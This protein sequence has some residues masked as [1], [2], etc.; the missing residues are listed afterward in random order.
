M[1]QIIYVDILIAVNLFINYFL[2]LVTAKFL[3][4]K[5][6]TWRVIIG[7]ILGGIYSLYILMPST[8]L[9]VSLLI[10]FFM[11]LTIVAVTFKF[12][13]IK[14]LLKTLICFY[15]INFAFSG[16][17][18]ALW[19][20]FKPKSMA[21]N[22]GI[23]YFGISPTALVISTVITYIILETINRII[24][25][26]HLSASFCNVK[27]FYRN[28]TCTIKAMVDTGN[29]L[30]EPFSGLSVIVATAESLSN[31][32]PHEILQTDFSDC[33]QFPGIINSKFRMIPFKTISGDGIIPA[34]K[35]EHVIIDNG[36]PKQAYIAVCSD[37]ILSSD[38]PALINSNLLD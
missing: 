37:K 33:S 19:C 30:V 15:A 4:L 23:V 18:L 14:T 21:V 25:K 6:K 38:C 5:L 24:A 27:I 28:K 31:I 9:F 13:E 3:S 34:F 22:N 7:E 8:N 29:S 35:P 11:S 16:I 17:M 32:C 20:S 26:H 1:K 12:R 36:A 10:K 2:I